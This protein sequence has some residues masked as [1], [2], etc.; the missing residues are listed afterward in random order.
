M[1]RN[2]IAVYCQDFRNAHTGTGFLLI[3]AQWSGPLHRNRFFSG[4]VQKELCSVAPKQERRVA[5]VFIE[6]HADGKT[7]GKHQVNQSE[8]IRQ[9]RWKILARSNAVIQKLKFQKCNVRQWFN[10]VRSLAIPA[11]RVP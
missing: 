3:A 9:G 2:E 4:S 8:W 7:F 11:P 1:H 6:V 10:S 5:A